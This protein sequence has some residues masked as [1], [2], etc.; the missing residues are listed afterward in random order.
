MYL[1]TI[2]IRPRNKDKYGY[3]ATNPYILI[4]ENI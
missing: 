4:N 3:L 2:Y 1:A